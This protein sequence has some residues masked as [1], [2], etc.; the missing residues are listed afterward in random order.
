MSLLDETSDR[1]S[2]FRR[3]ALGILWP[4]PRRDG[5]YRFRDKR[6]P[7]R[8]SMDGSSSSGNNSP[9]LS[10]HPI[11]WRAPPVPRRTGRLCR[12]LALTLTLVVL[13]FKYSHL[14]SVFRQR[15]M[16]NYLLAADPKERP[17]EFTNM[18]AGYKHFGETCR[19]SSLDLHRPFEPVC[20][21]KTSMLEAMSSG[22]RIGR[23]APYIPRDCDFRWFTT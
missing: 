16:D 5:E 3:D 1:T 23:D 12:Q 18:L 4:S 10:R 8:S 2:S 9:W 6:P 19:V 20:P 13:L 15:K 22:G 11:E 21:D 17:N 14:F 7:Q